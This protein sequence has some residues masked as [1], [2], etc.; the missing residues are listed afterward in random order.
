MTLIAKFYDI[1]LPIINVSLMLDG[2][3]LFL[4]IIKVRNTSKCLCYSQTYLWD[5]SVQWRK[6]GRI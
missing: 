1:I 5:S 3:M 6:V 2:V 4:H